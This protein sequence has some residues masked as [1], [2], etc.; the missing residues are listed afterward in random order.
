MANS[1]L[2]ANVLMLPLVVVR[3]SGG[4]PSKLPLAWIPV[5]LSE[6]RTRRRNDAQSFRT[7]PDF[8][9]KPLQNFELE[10]SSLKS[11]S[12][13]MKLISKTGCSHETVTSA[14]QDK[15]PCAVLKLLLFRQPQF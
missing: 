11:L 5:E 9:S 13:A 3:S 1:T 10:Y 4:A 15:Y 8:F 7:L 2:P 12:V 6:C 14:G